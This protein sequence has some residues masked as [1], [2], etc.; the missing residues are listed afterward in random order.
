MPKHAIGSQ[1]GSRWR[2]KNVVRTL[3]PRVRVAGVGW[4]SDKVFPSV[5]PDQE[6]YG[7][8]DLAVRPDQP[9]YNVAD[10]AVRGRRLSTSAG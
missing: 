5:R 4:T 6:V 7:R 9:V 2:S 1:P 10:L 8:Q 3:S